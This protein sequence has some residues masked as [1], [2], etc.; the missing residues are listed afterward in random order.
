MISKERVQ[1]ALKAAKAEDVEGST[2][3]AV[4]KELGIRYTWEVSLLARFVYQEEVTEENMK[5]VDEL[6]QSGGLN[7]SFL[8]GWVAC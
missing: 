1:R 8:I 6:Y 3:M 2:G 4:V 7:F 5:L